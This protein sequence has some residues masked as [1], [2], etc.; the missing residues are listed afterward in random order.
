MF[1]EIRIVRRRPGFYQNKPT[2]VAT[3]LRSHRFVAEMHRPTG[4]TVC[5]VGRA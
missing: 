4:R 2:A 5:R 3:V 1:L